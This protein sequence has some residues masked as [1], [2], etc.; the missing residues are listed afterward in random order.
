LI[1]HP[2]PLL[3]AP[4][5]ANTGSAWTIA[6]WSARF[7]LWTR[8]G[9]RLNA[10]PARAESIAAGLLPAAL[11]DISAPSTPAPSILDDLSRTMRRCCRMLESFC[12]QKECCFVTPSDRR[13]KREVA[14]AAASTCL[15]P[16][17]NA[18][19]DVIVDEDAR[20]TGTEP[21]TLEIGGMDCVDCL[22]KVDRALSRLPSC[23]CSLLAVCC[24]PSYTDRVWRC[25]LSQGQA[26]WS[27]L[28]RWYCHASL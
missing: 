9:P 17:E 14:P 22:P 11:P 24:P 4:A 12:A 21:L 13:K 6:L 20:S 1:R 5:R 7:S 8:S 28:P 16:K 19:A 18:K 10:L 2:L 23:V 25:C 27:R 3:R 26:A 15:Q